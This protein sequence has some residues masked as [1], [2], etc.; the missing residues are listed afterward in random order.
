MVQ[1]KGEY[2]FLDAYGQVWKL[3]PT[4]ERDRGGPLLIVLLSRV[5]FNPHALEEMGL[6]R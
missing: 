1:D 3:V 2:I 6:D 4:F 5:P